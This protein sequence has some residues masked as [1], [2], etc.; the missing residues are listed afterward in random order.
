MLASH[1]PLHPCHTH[2]H[3]FASD[4]I[5]RMEGC[6][7]AQWR[8]QAYATGQLRDHLDEVQRGA[9]AAALQLEARLDGAAREL[10][11]QAAR[12]QEVERSTQAAGAEALARA[13]AGNAP[14]AAA[15]PARASLVTNPAYEGDAA[16]GLEAIMRRWG[17]GRRAKRDMRAGCGGRASSLPL[18]LLPTPPAAG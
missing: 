14:A 15:R 4:V 12:L 16:V 6:C 17:R 9:A 2:T 10:A 5:Q 11:A 8:Q 18:W 1:H 3:K 13:P 7:A